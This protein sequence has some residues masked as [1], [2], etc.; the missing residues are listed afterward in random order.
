MK[1]LHLFLITLVIV[2]VTSCSKSSSSTPPVITD[3]KEAFTDKNWWGDYQDP[4]TRYAVSRYSLEFTTGNN[5][6][7][8]TIRGDSSGTYTLKDNLIEITIPGGAIK[9]SAEVRDKK[10]A[11]FSNFSARSIT[12]LNATQNTDASEQPI[13]N[14]T[15][16]GSFTDAGSLTLDFK[17]GNQAIFDTHVS[18]YV[19][20]KGGVIVFEYVA[21][22]WNR[23]FSII[24]GP[25]TLAGNYMNGF[26]N[27]NS[28]FGTKQ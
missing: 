15:W 1:P 24:T 22:R 2:M 19:R 27:Y 4:E 28:Y 12:F 5:V 20:K 9:F 16:R 23:F 21:H 13:D 14:T 7:L 17:P 10:L 8:H 6:I 11:N 3:P 18:T 26:E 25:N